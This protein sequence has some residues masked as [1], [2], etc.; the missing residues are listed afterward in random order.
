MEE[1]TLYVVETQEPPAQ[2]IFRYN[3][4]LDAIVAYFNAVAANYSALK[5]GSVE[6]FGVYLK[7]K[8]MSIITS[9]VK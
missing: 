2:N 3:D 4:E 5:A 9:E 8:D 1:V 6:H 7:N